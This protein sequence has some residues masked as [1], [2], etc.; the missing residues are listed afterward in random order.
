MVSVIVR[1]GEGIDVTVTH[2]PQHGVK[3][4]SADTPHA[5]SSAQ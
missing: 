1:L 4:P 5:V 3:A 2:V